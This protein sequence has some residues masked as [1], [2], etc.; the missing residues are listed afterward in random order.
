VKLAQPLFV[1]DFETNGLSFETDR[2]VI[3]IQVAGLAL[4][5]TTLKVIPGSEFE[6]L[7]RPE[8]MATLDDNP[9]KKGALAVNKKRPEDIAKAPTVE[10]V[11]RRFASHV[12]QYQKGVRRPYAA[13]KNIRSFDL[14]LL[15]RVCRDHSF[16]DKDGKNSL[17]DR[18][19]QFDIEDDL[20]RW[21]GFGDV[22]P[23]MKMDTLRG[24]LGMDKT[25]SHD[26]GKDVAQTA[27]FLAKILRLYRELQPKIK[28]AGSAAG[29]I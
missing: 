21:F 4:D 29:V 12:K 13:G 17:F 6:S 24:F 3:P 18:R 26:A 15:D 14:P 2:T 20:H 19:I 1:F 8:D 10:V 11:M 16:A 7:M 23:N 27:W 22:L 28:F 25:N 9:E 5:P